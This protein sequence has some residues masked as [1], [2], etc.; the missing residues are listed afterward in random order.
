M[1]LICRYELGADGGAADVQLLVSGPDRS[2]RHMTVERGIGFIGVR[3]RPGWARGIL[4]STHR[5]WWMS[6]PWPAL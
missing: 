3:F 5:R 4:T 1:D 6:A 2:T